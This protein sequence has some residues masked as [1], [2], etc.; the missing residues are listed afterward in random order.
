MFLHAHYIKFRKCHNSIQIAK[1][2]VV[3]ICVY[4]K[5]PLV[6]KKKLERTFLPCV[7]EIMG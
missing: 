6:Q 1:F 2:F 7:Y 4:I 5:K 3:G